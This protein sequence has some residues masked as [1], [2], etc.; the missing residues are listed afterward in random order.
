[1]LPVLLAIILL[2]ILVIIFTITPEDL[3]AAW[4]DVAWPKHS[5]RKKPQPNSSSKR[6]DAPVAEEEE[7]KHKMPDPVKEYVL[8]Y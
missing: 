1:M 2:P 3:A 8:P 5:P 7:P 6:S 4:Q